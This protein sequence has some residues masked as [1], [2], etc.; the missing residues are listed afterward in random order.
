MLIPSRQKR[1]FRSGHTR[2]IQEE[3]E[4]LLPG[5]D[6]LFLFQRD[7]CRTLRMTIKPDGAV[8]VRAPARLPLEDVFSFV[9]SRLSWIRA[10]KDFFAAHHGTAA[11]LREGES[12]LYLARPFTICPVPV[13]KNVRARLIGHRL[14]LPCLR[15]GAEETD[16]A[17]ALERAFL[18]WRLDTAKRLLGRRLARMERRARAVF[19]D[20]A[21]PASL[22]VRSLRRRWGSCSLHGD[23]TL[24]VQLI[25]LP[26]PLI[27]YVLCHELCHLRAMN[28]GPSFHILLHALLP[29]ARNREKLIRIW[30]LEHP[31]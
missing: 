16:T 10:K 19:G 11:P 17:R 3:K 20:R 21:A 24:A 28:H 22:T 9:R 18:R 7:G 8:T 12:I 27:D 4:L 14:E 29:D 15:P 26:L 13:R 31:R 1:S 30:S 25:A 6:L 5:T 23:I 2:R